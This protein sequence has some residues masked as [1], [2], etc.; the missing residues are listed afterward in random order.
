MK[1]VVRNGSLSIEGLNSFPINF[2]VGNQNVGRMAD[3]SKSFPWREVA[4]HVARRDTRPIVAMD[5]AGTFQGAVDTADFAKEY[6]GP[7]QLAVKMAGLTAPGK[8]QLYRIGIANGKVSSYFGIVLPASAKNASIAITCERLPPTLVAFYRDPGFSDSHWFMPD[9]CVLGVY[10]EYDLGKIPQLLRFDAHIKDGSGRLLKQYR[11]QW[12]CTDFSL[13]EDLPDEPRIKRVSGPLANR[14]TYLN[15]GYSAFQRVIDVARENG[16][17]VRPQ[18]QVLDWGVGCGRVAR[19]FAKQ[20]EAQITGVDIDS[21]NVGWCRANLRGTY[22][23]VKLSP[24]TSLRANAFDLI[25][26]CSVL[27][28]LSKADADAWLGEMARVLAPGGLA[29]LSFNGSSNLSSYLSRRPAA[30]RAALS[31]GLFFGDDNNDLKGFI[32]SDDYY[33]ATFA[34][35]E[36]WAPMFAKHFK[37]VKI[38]ECV[39][40]GHQH[41]A[42]LR[43]M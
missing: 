28:H 22:E 38:E 41:F 26:S 39:V 1:L 19:F 4:L 12:S 2:W 3:A 5:D 31:E 35:D 37:V 32:P 30:L 11:P 24:P 42:V 8:W 25:Y 27:S 29:L 18:T 20:T 16:V 17:F 43:K 21:D 36:W 9:A 6:F 7:D 13:L 10:C 15:G 14:I 40:S 34:T 23:T 33:K